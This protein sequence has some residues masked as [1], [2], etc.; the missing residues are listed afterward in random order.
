[1]N[2]EAGGRILISDFVDP[3]RFYLLE[4]S[5][6]H[7]IEQRGSVDSSPKSSGFATYRRVGLGKRHR[8]F[9]ALYSTGQTLMVQLGGESFYFGNKELIAKRVT[10]PVFVRRFRIYR[11]Q[12]IVVDMT[13]WFFEWQEWPNDGDIFSLIAKD[14]ATREDRLRSI[15]FFG[16]NSQGRDVTN[17]LFT[18]EM[19]T[20]VAERISE[21]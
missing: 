1:M 8:V 5:S 15:Y 18:Q 10:V 17:P 19:D 21:V 2:N 12:A 7:V 11:G 16:A 9:V 4:P 20:W 14:T 6:G 13:Y 3:F